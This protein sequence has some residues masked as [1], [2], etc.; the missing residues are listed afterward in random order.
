MTVQIYFIGGKSPEMKKRSAIFITE[1][2]GKL[3]NMIGR[4]PRESTEGKQRT[5]MQ[6]KGMEHL[7]FIIYNYNENTQFRKHTYKLRDIRFLGE[8]RVGNK[9]TK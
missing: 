9:P 7:I 1:Q 2:M 8:I 5:H 6:A 3:L 4:L